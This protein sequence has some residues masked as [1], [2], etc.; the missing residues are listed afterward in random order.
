[1]AFICMIGGEQGKL[2]GTGTYY[3]GVRDTRYLREDTIHP[4]IFAWVKTIFGGYQLQLS[5]DTGRKQISLV[6]IKIT[7]I[8]PLYNKI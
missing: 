5:C 4:G 2:H 3:A 8:H 7:R 6:G 1:M